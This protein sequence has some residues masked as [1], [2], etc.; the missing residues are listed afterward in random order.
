M[1]VRAKKA[2]LA[3]RFGAAVVGTVLL[4]CAAILWL[5]HGETLRLRH[6]STTRTEKHVTFDEGY[7]TE[8]VPTPT[9]LVSLMLV[10][11]VLLL[12]VAMNDGDL[13][14]LRLPGGS[15]KF[16]DKQRGL[17][18]AEASARTR[19]PVEAAKL[20]LD[21]VEELRSSRRV[22]M[23][24]AVTKEVIERAVEEAFEQEDGPTTS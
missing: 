15:I 2:P 9:A 24:G 13:S 21:T 4:V 11:G 20:A 23:A 1:H 3:G 14:E 17:I 5:S 22:A 18:A 16:G 10:G 19:D 8:E 7:R 12:I 6:S